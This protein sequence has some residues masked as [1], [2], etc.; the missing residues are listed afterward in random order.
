[1]ALLALGVV[2]AYGA[3]VLLSGQATFTGFIRLDDT[4]TWYNIVDH[5]FSHARS[6]A[7]EPPST[8]KLVFTGDVG[9]S[10]PLGAFMLPGVARAVAL[11][12]SLLPRRPRHWR[13]LVPLAVALG[14]LLQTLGPG[15][16]GWVA[17]AL[18]V[19]CGIWLYEERRS[20][21]PRALLGMVSALAT[22]V[23]ACL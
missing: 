13:E 21:R 20:G 5:V 11:T 16:G 2:L 22:L 10:Y 6:V 12:A 15:G 9:P 17:P 3:P 1:P 8:Y 7:G 4:S 18:I 14:A 23:A 19:L